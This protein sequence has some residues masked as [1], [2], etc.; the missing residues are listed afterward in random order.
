V[1][2]VSLLFVL[3]SVL[4]YALTDLSIFKYVLAN[5]L[6]GL[7]MAGLLGA[8]LRFIVLRETG[9]GDHASGQGLLSVASSIGRLLGAAI[10]GSIATSAGG[11]TIGYQSAFTGM[12]VLG[13][14]LFVVAWFL[15]TRSTKSTTKSMTTEA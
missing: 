13:A 4:I 3:S 7:G 9:P 14:M 11:G 8:P 15:Q 5:M 6:S 1:I 2:L 12:A 10:V